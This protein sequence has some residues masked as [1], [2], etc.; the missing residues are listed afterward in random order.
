M[1]FNKMMVLSLNK[2]ILHELVDTPWRGHLGLA[3]DLQPAWKS[4]YKPLLT[5]RVDDLQWRVLHGIVAVNKFLSV[6]SPGL[7]NRCPYC[8][9][10]ETVFHCFH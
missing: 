10:K 9:E 1:P 7:S 4:L 3:V 8:D 5:K 2:S 6:I